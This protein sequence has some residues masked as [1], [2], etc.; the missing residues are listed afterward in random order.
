M[1]CNFTAVSTKRPHMCTANVSLL[2][3]VM[4]TTIQ[5]TRVTSVAGQSVIV[6][7]HYLTRSLELQDMQL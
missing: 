5:L 7:V 1:S 3:I 2:S 4:N 6:N